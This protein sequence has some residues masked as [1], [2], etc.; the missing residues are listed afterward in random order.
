MEEE[1]IKKMLILIAIAGLFIAYFI[2]DL[3]QYLSL[4]TL[5]KLKDDIETFYLNNQLLTIFSFFGIYVLATSVSIPGATILTLAAGAIFGVWMGTLIVSFASTIGASFAFLASRILLGES[6][7]QKY[8]DK[9]K[10]INE[11]VEKDGAFYLFS[12]RLAPV[13]PFFLINL[14]MGLTKMPLLK[15]AIVSQIGMLPGT[16]LYVYAGET[17][18]S[19][20]KLS[21]IMSPKI[22][23]VFILFA[24]LPLII[25]YGL[26]FWKE[27]IAPKNQQ[28]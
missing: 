24:V 4:E 22:L 27:K 13:F 18:S 17:L 5:K 23:S 10:V 11:G 9:L 28:L 20:E 8:P 21:D 19:I 16:I 7:Q 1:M 15:Y 25:K 3:G 6:L 12:L 2:F 26:K 14:L